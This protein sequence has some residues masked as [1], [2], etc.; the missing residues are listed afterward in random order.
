MQSCEVGDQGGNYD[1]LSLAGNS[2]MPPRVYQ[3]SQTA[4]QGASKIPSCGSASSYDL[5]GIITG[6]ALRAEAVDASIKQDSFEQ[7]EDCKGTAGLNPVAC[8]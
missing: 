5:K 3:R 4:A 2:G 6:F 1:A 8:I 7:L